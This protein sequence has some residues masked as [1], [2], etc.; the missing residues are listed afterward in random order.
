MYLFGDSPLKKWELKELHSVTDKVTSLFVCPG[1]DRS[2]IKF[3]K[4]NKDEDGGV[5]GADK[6]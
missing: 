3:Q 6:R 1:I 2:T 4:G 5:N